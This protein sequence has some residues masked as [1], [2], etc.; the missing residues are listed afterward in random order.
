MKNK[1]SRCCGSNVILR[2]FHAL[3]QRYFRC[4]R[5]NKFCAT[6]DK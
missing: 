6:K 5:C 4:L 2:V 1:V 3:G